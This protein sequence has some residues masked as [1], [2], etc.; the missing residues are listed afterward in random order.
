[1]QK[2]V[3]GLRFIEVKHSGKNI[4]ERVAAVVEEF[5]LIDKIFVVTLDNAASNAK[6]METLTLMFAGT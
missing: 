2:N 5:C 4:A 3:I 6:A 1:L